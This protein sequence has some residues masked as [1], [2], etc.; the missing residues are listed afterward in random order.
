MRLPRLC[1]ILRP[2]RVALGR[3]L[4]NVV[5]PL[6]ASL[7]VPR[8]IDDCRSSSAPERALAALAPCFISMPAL[9]SIST[10]PQSPSH[11]PTLKHLPHRPSRRVSLNPHA[12]ADALS[13]QHARQSPHQTASS[14][15]K[16]VHR[17]QILHATTLRRPSSR[18]VSLAARALADPTATKPLRSRLSPTSLVHQKPVYPTYCAFSLTASPPP[19][20][21]RHKLKRA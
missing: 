18:F 8:T 9:Q 17:Y 11:L 7:I 3:A 14:P 1:T 16:R 21:K 12:P 19:G 20:P 2:G 5:K 10:S 4:A 13:P 15:R 6:V